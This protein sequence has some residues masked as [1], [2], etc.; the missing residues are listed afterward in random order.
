MNDECDKQSIVSLLSQLSSESSS[1]CISSSDSLLSLKQPTPYYQPILTQDARTKANTIS[2]FNDD[3][4]V[5]YF[6]EHKITV[7]IGTW[8]MASRQPPD[9]M[10]SFALPESVQYLADVLVFGVQEAP[11]GDFFDV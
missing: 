4:L 11:Q 1:F 5:K 8:N 3:E 6:P 7:Y 2:M 10:N 9:D